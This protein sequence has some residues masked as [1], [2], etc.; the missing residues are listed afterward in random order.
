MES[1]Q[2][3]ELV[4][5]IRRLPFGFPQHF[6][7]K[8]RGH[9]EF[10]S[11]FQQ[12]FPI[13]FLSDVFSFFGTALIGAVPSGRDEELGSIK[14]SENWLQLVNKRQND[15]EEV[16]PPVFE[17]PIEKM[18]L[19]FAPKPPKEERKRVPSVPKES[20]KPREI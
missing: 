15:L 12:F 8:G 16:S 6:F 10:L 9:S 18:N 14:V 13:H 19:F 3:L 20:Q 11:R 17:Q 4:R 5:F 1:P 7:K 2:R